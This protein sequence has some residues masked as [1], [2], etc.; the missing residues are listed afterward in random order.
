MFDLPLVEALANQSG[1]GHLT[2]RVPPLMVMRNEYKLHLIEVLS[3]NLVVGHLDMQIYSSY[4]YE[5]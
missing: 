3:C 4:G 5:E 2:Y 1:V